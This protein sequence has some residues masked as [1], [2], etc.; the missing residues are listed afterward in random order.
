MSNKDFEI[1]PLVSEKSYALANALNKYMFM[2]PKG[3]NKI[4]IGKKIAAKYNVKVTSVNTVTKPG[5][6]QK[7]YQVNTVKRKS[8]GKKAFVTLKDGDKIKEFFEI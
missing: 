5:K 7:N 4:E 8:D 1:R 6:L 3:M 2:V